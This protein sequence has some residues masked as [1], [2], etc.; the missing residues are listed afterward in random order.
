MQLLEGITIGHYHIQRRL[1]KG[2][3]SVV[4]L[5]Q[6]TRTQQMV[7]IKMVHRSAGEYCERFRRETH[8][9]A[10]LKHPHILPALDYGEYESWYYLVT[11]Y[12][13]YGTLHD[14]LARGS[15]SQEEAGEILAQLADALQCAHE[16]GMVHRDIKASNVLLH[17]G[18]YVYLADFGLVKSAGAAHSLTQSG[19]L[20]GTPEYMA[21]E[22][23]DTPPTVA[24]DVYAL[25][26]LLYQMLTGRLPFRGD[27]P[28]V[29]V[30]QHIKNKPEAPSSLNPAIS[31]AVEQVILCAMAKKP[32]ERFPT[33]QDMAHAYQRALNPQAC[34]ITGS[35]SSSVEV[36]PAVIRVVPV[37][38]IAL[39]PVRSP[40]MW[41]RLLAVLLLTT[42]LLAALVSALFYLVQ[43]LS[44]H[45]G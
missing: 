1:A 37:S 14:R 19:Y 24:S 30:W 40:R 34:A 17:E 43:V 38:S 4:Y 5:A 44:S 22:L 31:Q 25:G 13:A 36:P 18:K 20:I 26:V 33:T 45:G 3:M 41:V 16:H 29:T 21:P 7:A 2:G 27:T 28:V 23:V 35:T 10:R 12:I 42:L 32:Q 8:V 11:P 15:L 6:D 39:P 9:V